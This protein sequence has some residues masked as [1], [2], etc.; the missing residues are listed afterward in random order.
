[1]DNLLIKN[2]SFKSSLLSEALGLRICCTLFWCS[3]WSQPGHF[4]YGDRNARTFQDKGTLIAEK[5]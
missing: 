3:L 1:M 2:F 5:R 4:I